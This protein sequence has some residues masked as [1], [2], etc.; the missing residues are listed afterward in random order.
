MISRKVWCDG[1]CPQCLITQLCPFAKSLLLSEDSPHTA[2][3]IAYTVGSAS[4]SR[5]GSSVHVS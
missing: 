1:F 5:S 4:G 3:S 2:H